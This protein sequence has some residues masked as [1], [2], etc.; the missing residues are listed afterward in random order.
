MR[1]WW[2]EIIR[3]IGGQT[4]GVGENKIIKKIGK[5]TWGVGENKIIT[6]IDKQTLR[7]WWK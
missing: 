5:Q 2:I 6:K 1:G 4:W 7:G 3:K